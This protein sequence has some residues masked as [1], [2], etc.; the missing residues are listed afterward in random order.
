LLTN[1][2]AD[3]NGFRFGKDRFVADHNGLTIGGRSFGWRECHEPEGQPRRRDVVHHSN[4]RGV[5]NSHMQHDHCG[6]VRGRGKQV[7]RDRHQHDR[8][9]SHGRHRRRRGRAS[10]TSSSSSSSRSSSADSQSSIESLPEYDDLLDQQLYNARK[11]LLDW[12]NHPEQPITRQAVWNIK[13]DIKSIKTISPKVYDEDLKILRKEVKDLMKKF[14][15]KKRTQRNIQRE[16]KKEK[17]AAKRAAKR[18]RRLARREARRG[19]RAEKGK[20]KAKDEACNVPSGM[21]MPATSTVDYRT[22][23][24]P[25]LTNPEQSSGQYFPFVRA[26]SAPMIQSPPSDRPGAPPA[27]PGPMHVGWSVLQQGDHRPVVEFG[28]GGFPA[29]ISH[30]AADIHYQ[31]MQMDLKAVEHEKR[32]IDL[33]TE[34]TGHDVPESV[35]VAKKQAAT[36]LEEVAEVCR[37]EAERLGAEGL[38][39]DEELARELSGAGEGLQ[40]TG[41]VQSH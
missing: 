30:S 7:H 21:K 41:I 38:L 31:A 2:R 16:L 6:Y 26:A 19:K 17:R 25:Y 34:A 28:P 13:E 15:E 27:L 4:K 39:L 37:M 23:P 10:S 1:H 24:V 5:N 9:H 29:S 8:S 18:E 20:F 35:R 11:A 36:A 14:R 3:Q 40:E 32:A 12:L 33:R 22:P